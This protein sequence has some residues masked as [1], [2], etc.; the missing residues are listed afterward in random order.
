MRHALL[1]LLLFAISTTNVLC[2][3]YTRQPH[4]S[5]AARKAFRDIES[6]FKRKDSCGTWAFECGDYGLCCPLAEHCVS[7]P[8]SIHQ[9]RR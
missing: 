5:K 1:S 3:T 2:A 7:T 9:F 4:A 6:V 8:E